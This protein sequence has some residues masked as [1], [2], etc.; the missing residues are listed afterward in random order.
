MLV[1]PL[2]SRTESVCLFDSGCSVGTVLLPFGV[3][4]YLASNAFRLTPENETF[5]ELRFRFMSGVWTFANFCFR[6]PF[7]HSQGDLPQAPH[8]PA[9]RLFWTFVTAILLRSMDL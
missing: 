2:S 1:F 8:N 7:L 3:R 9:S 6:A 4:S 5:Q